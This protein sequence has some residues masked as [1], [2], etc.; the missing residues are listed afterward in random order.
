MSRRENSDLGGHSYK[1]CLP[2]DLVF[3]DTCNFLFPLYNEPHRER[4]QLMLISNILSLSP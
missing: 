3:K 2:G 1:I 4:A